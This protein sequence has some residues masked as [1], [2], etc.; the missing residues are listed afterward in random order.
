MGLNRMGSSMTEVGPFNPVLGE[1][2]PA[3][4]DR[5]SEKLSL[6]QSGILIDISRPAEDHGVTAW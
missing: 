2:K 6:S 3:Q 1:T 5:D 4:A